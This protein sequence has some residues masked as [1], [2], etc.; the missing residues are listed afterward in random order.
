LLPVE[1]A[2]DELPGLAMSQGDAASIS[3]GQAVIVRGRDAPVSAGA[4]WVHYKGR[5]LALGELD[6]GAFHPTRVFN[7]G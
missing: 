1:A 3:R 6:K 5:I 2:L 7:F 4:A